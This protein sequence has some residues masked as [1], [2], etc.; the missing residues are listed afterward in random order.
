M[1]VQLKR[2]M[3]SMAIPD[4]YNRLTGRDLLRNIGEGV[5]MVAG[6]DIWA[7]YVGTQVYQRASA[8]GKTAVIFGSV[9]FKQGKWTKIKI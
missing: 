5:K 7:K 1:N 4:R 8:F 3:L 6:P 2:Q 9:R